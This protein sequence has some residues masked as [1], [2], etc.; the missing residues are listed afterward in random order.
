MILEI[1]TVRYV[2]YT[3]LIIHLKHQYYYND[4]IKNME[5]MISEMLEAETLFCNV[6]PAFAD[7][8]DTVYSDYLFFNVYDT[9]DN[10]TNEYVETEVGAV[11]DK[12]EDIISRFN[13]RILKHYKAEFKVS[14][15]PLVSKFYK[16]T[17]A[18]FEILT[19]SRSEEFFDLSFYVI[20]NKFRKEVF[21]LLIHA[22]K[23]YK[24]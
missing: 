10:L 23:I 5:V 8:D 19:D 9:F 22:T 20:E 24:S 12:I 11:K 15:Y 21:D 2:G 14:S 16:T 17:G 13:D 1:K 4:D 3:L 6:K 18:F 7:N